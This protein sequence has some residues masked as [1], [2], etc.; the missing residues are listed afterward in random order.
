MKK[1]IIILCFIV[2]GTSWAKTRAKKVIQSNHF[3]DEVFLGE[4]NQGEMVGPL[5]PIFKHNGINYLFE[6]HMGGT[7]HDNAYHYVSPDAIDLGLFWTRE[8]PRK[9]LCPPFYLNQNIQYIRYLYRLLA[10]SGLYEVMKDVSNTSTRLGNAPRCIPNADT[11]FS[12]CKSATSEDMK[13]FIMRGRAKL[14]SE[15]TPYIGKFTNAAETEWWKS[16]GIG[17][18]N[19]NE[20]LS[21]AQLRVQRWCSENDVDCLNLSKERFLDA[22]HESCEQ[23]K[24]LFTLICNESDE[25]YGISKLEGYKEALLDSHIMRVINQGGHAESCLETYSGIFAHA[26]QKPLHGLSIVPYVFK[27]RRE[28]KETYI[29]GELF[30]PGALKEFDD[31]GLAEFLFATPTPIATA[32]PTP[33][34]VATPKPTPLPTVAPTPSPTP[35]VVATSVPTP[36]PTPKPSEFKIS[37]NYLVQNDFTSWPVDMTKF[38]D[39]FIFTDEMV[40]AL[41]KPL[42]NYQTRKA[43]EGMKQF[44]LLGTEREPVR[45]IFLKFLIDRSQHQ[46]LYNIVAVLGKEFYVLNDID[47]HKDGPVKVRLQQN[48]LIFGGWSIAILKEKTPE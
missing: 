28:N 18:K 38:H 10:M 6:H 33:V 37:Y 41:E 1:L 12:K 29:Q 40:K 14:A 31:K 45:L 5:D 7:L 23:D 4:R 16:F 36:K 46:G 44:E 24:S 30:V 9:S 13:R 26:E 25:L 42:Q 48:S 3:Y 22:L 35:M 43:L 17:L 39:D 8:I 21:L 27:E 32:A 47:G 34:A 20:G 19:N 2:A 15:K 11:L